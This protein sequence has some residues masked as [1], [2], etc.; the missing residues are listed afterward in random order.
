MRWAAHPNHFHQTLE[1]EKKQKK[2]LRACVL[3]CV[4]TCAGA[5]ARRWFNS[6]S[7]TRVSAS[8]RNTAT[9][10]ENCGQRDYRGRVGWLNFF[11]FRRPRCKFVGQLCECCKSEHREWCPVRWEVS[12]QYIQVWLGETQ[13]SLGHLQHY[14]GNIRSLTQKQSKEIKKKVHSEAWWASG[15][16]KIIF[17]CV[18]PICS[19]KTVY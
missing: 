4:C 10:W 8:D 19:L 3:F 13:A 5:C 15:D 12:D 2:Q 7:V 6:L 14:S 17:G 11:I 18:C 1:G 16:E 9:P